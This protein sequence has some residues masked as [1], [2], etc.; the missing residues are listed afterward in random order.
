MYAF[1]WS[2]SAR[3][4][5]GYSNGQCSCV[6]PASLPDVPACGPGRPAWGLRLG[7]EALLAVLRHGFATL[8]AM[9]IVTGHRTAHKDSRKL[10][11]RVGFEYTH[12][13][14]WGPT[15]IDVFMWVMTAEKWR[16]WHGAQC[17]KRALRSD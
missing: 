6:T 13:I 16:Q 15:E 4:A 14:L 2:V 1:T 17:D 5:L 11:A 3:T 10:L 9:S 8:G 12:N 7:E